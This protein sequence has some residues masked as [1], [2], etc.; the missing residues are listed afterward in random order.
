[1]FHFRL[2]ENNENGALHAQVFASQLLMNAT[3]SRFAPRC[4]FHAFLTNEPGTNERFHKRIKD[5]PGLRPEPRMPVLYHKDRAFKVQRSTSLSYLRISA[6][7][8]W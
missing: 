6:A 8:A 4:E 2:K 1:M 7:D 5:K 3:P